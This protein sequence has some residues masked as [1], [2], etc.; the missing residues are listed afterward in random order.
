[1]AEAASKG[2]AKILAILWA[3]NNPPVADILSLVRHNS[4]ERQIRFDW[5]TEYGILPIHLL[6]CMSLDINN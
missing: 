3:E 5:A 6:H 2:L 4:R 1:M